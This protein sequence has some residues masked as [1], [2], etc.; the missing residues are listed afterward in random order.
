MNTKKIVTERASVHQ[1]SGENQKKL[2]ESEQIYS[3]KKYKKGSLAA[4][5]NMVKDYNES[6]RN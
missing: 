5:A 4:K 1:A 3:Q 6:S 2:E